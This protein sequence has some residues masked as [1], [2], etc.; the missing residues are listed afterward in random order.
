MV[1]FRKRF[2]EEGMQRIE[3]CHCVSV[4]AKGGVAGGPKHHSQKAAAPEE[5]ADDDSEPPA[6]EN[7]HQIPMPMN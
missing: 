3:R 1:D 2:G 4:V 7:M 6:A 5:P